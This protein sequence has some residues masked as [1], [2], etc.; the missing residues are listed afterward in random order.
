[1]LSPLHNRQTGPSMLE[2]PVSRFWWLAWDWPWGY[3][4]LPDKN[5]DNTL[6]LATAAFFH[7]ISNSLFTVVQS[8]SLNYCQHH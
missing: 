8:Y 2:A 4:V 5:W 1:M 6:N 3:A 7:V